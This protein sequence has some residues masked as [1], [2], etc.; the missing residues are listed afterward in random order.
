MI[1]TSKKMI[2][3]GLMSEDS[4]YHINNHVTQYTVSELEKRG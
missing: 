1:M 4:D 2:A 3:N